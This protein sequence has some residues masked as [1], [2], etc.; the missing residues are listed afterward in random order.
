VSS[1]VEAVAAGKILDRV[2]PHV[3]IAP[4]RVHRHRKGLSKVRRMSVTD[5][6]ML[7]TGGFNGGIHRGSEE[8]LDCITRSC[9]VSTTTRI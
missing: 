1:Q 8:S 7:V 6:T 9:P 3:A 5:I 4:E 2:G